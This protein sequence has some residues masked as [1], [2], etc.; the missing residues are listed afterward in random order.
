MKTLKEK[1]IEL[2]LSL[3]KPEIRSSKQQLNRLLA[4]DFL[5]IPSTGIPYNKSQAL[6][7][8]PQEIPSTFVLQDFES[9]NVVQ[10]IYKAKIMRQNQDAIAYSQRSSIWK[11]T[12]GKWQM[13]FHQGTPCQPFDVIEKQ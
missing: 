10:L 1:I 8:I 13:M 5:E 12:A 2:E 9:K 3:L 6:S 7:H 4:D 11:K